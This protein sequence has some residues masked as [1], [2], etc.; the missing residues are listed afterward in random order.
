MFLVISSSSIS[1]EINTRDKLWGSIGDKSVSCIIY[2]HI[3]YFCLVLSQNIQ[4]AARS[5][6]VKHFWLRRNRHYL[7]MAMKT[8]PFYRL[9]CKPIFSSVPFNHIWFPIRTS[10]TTSIGRRHRTS[11]GVVFFRFFSNLPLLNFFIFSGLFYLLLRLGND[12]P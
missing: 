3:L 11:T 7:L 6:N 4:S 5:D 8:L 9:L 12:Y 10:R 2:P 1:N